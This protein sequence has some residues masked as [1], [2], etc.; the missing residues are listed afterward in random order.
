MKICIFHRRIAPALAAE[1]GASLAT[2][3]SID[4]VTDVQRDPP[5]VEDIEVL[6]AN[7]LPAGLLARCKKLRWL[8][9]TGTGYD[10]ILGESPPR[11]LVVTNAGD[12]PARAVAEFAWM[13][14]LSL[15]KEGPALVRQQ[16]A[17]IWKL[18]DARLV[19]GTTLVIAGL[20]PIGRAIARR[21]AGFDVRTIGVTRTGS[22]PGVTDEIY[23][24]NEI[25]RV[26]PVADHVVIALPGLPQTRGLFGAELVDRLPAQAVLINVSRGSILDTS[27]VIRA[28]RERRLRAALLDVH[29]QEPL[30]V[31][32]PAWTTENLWVTP[33]GAF[34]YPGET[35]DLARLIADNLRRFRRGEPLHNRIDPFPSASASAAQ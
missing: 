25:A 26:L 30:P 11:G 1:I 13:G 34:C 12:I 27:A 2:D 32:H 3:E 6:I 21:A 4:V 10:H 5:N 14:I 7:T 33:H 19:A 23:A 35:Y 24:W 15:A 17:R 20:G 22:S 8:Q 16:D 28:L 9:L 29:E 18:P 31:E